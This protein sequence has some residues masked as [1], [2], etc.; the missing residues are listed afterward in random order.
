MYMSVEKTYFLD[1]CTPIKQKIFPRKILTLYCDF[2]WLGLDS[3][4]A[5]V[6]IQRSHFFGA[7]LQSSS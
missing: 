1:F 4:T 2:D 3:L 6:H 7:D 5:G